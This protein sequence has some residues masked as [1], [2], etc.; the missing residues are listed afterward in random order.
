MTQHVNNECTAC[1]L[2]ERQEEQSKWAA[3]SIEEKVE[4]LLKRVRRLEGNQHFHERY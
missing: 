2:R 3:L 1:K 4:E